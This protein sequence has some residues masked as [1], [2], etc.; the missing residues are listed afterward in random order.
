MRTHPLYCSGKA[1]WSRANDGQGG[2]SRQ[3][4]IEVAVYKC[5]YSYTYPQCHSVLEYA[6][7]THILLLTYQISVSE[8]VFV[9]HEESF[10]SDA[11]T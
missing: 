6:G 1:L 11:K 8:V 7:S 4:L 5:T 10:H 9:V 2:T 3:S